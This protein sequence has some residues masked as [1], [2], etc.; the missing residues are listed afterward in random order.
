MLIPDGWKN[1]ELAESE[2]ETAKYLKELGYA[3]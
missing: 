3:A 2:K 1:T